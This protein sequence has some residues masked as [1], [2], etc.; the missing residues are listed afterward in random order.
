LM[1][2][3]RLSCS[4][5]CVAAREP[6]DGVRYIA[7]VPCAPL[8]R[9]LWRPR[10]GR[11]PWEPATGN[12][13]RCVHRCW[14]GLAAKRHTAYR[15]THA[16]CCCTSCC[17]PGAHR[18]LCCRCKAALGLKRRPTPRQRQ[19]ITL[20]RRAQLTSAVQAPFFWSSAHADGMFGS[21]C[22]YQLALL[23]RM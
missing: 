11:A 15:H 18:G 6:A 23:R 2:T 19:G 20:T 14:P 3:S 7:W 4:S 22:C 17:G 5:S 9:L 16:T 21:C 13:A 1:M 12:I 8:L 10:A